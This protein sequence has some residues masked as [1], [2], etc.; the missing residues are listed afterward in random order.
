MTHDVV[1]L[2]TLARACTDAALLYDAAARAL[3]DAIHREHGA[4]DDEW[5]A[6]DDA[7]IMLRACRNTYVEGLRQEINGTLAF[8]RKVAESL[9]KVSVRACETRRSNAARRRLALEPRPA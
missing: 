4:T 6:E 2:G 3:D 8:H 1:D 7:R 5:L 9:S